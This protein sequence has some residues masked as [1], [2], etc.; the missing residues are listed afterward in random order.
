MLTAV[1]IAKNEAADLAVCLSSLKF[2]DEILVIDDLSTDQTA[3]V[4][5]K[6]HARVIKHPLA[7]DFAQQRNFGLK[8]SRHPWVL[9]VDADEEVNPHLA[10]EIK[11]AVSQKQFQGFY[12]PR[13]DAMWGQILKHGDAGTVK[14]LRLGQKNIGAWQGQVHETWQIK[15][16]TAVLNHPLI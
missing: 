4:A 9:F 5:K 12:L 11:A 7:D 16:P 15:G 10:A 6:F 3:R 13:V 2:C 8:H 14:L 1:V